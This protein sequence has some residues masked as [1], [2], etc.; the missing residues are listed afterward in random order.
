MTERAGT[1]SRVSS[2]DQRKGYSPATMLAD[3]RAYH[4]EHG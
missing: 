3:I 2:E 4:A 1:Y